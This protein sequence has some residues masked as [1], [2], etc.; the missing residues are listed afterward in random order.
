MPA[1]TLKSARPK[2]ATRSIA[3]PRSKRRAPSEPT[4]SEIAARMSVAKAMFNAT[5]AGAARAAFLARRG[6]GDHAA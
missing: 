3:K 4:K 2:K 6:A 1:T 5:A